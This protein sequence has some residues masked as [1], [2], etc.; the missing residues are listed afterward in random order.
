[1]IVSS[2][3]SIV[4][5]GALS[6]YVLDVLPGQS[7]PNVYNNDKM[8]FVASKALKAGRNYVKP[9]CSADHPL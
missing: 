8:I 1:M 3:F 9:V 2:Q 7:F 4:F 5:Y 6:V